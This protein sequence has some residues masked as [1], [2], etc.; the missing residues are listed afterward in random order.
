MHKLLT[1]LLVLTTSLLF[2]QDEDFRNYDNIYQGNIATVRFHLNGLDLSYPIIDINSSGQLR[3][4]FDDLD[5]DVKNY[6]YTIQHCDADW[7]PSDLDEMEYL[8]GFTE[9]RI[10]N[11]QYSFTTRVPYTHYE[12]L[13][14]NNDIGW[15]VSGNYILKVYEDEGDKKLVITR[16]FMVVEPIVQINQRV[17]IPNMVSKSKT[18]QEIDFVVSHE[19]LDIR[20]PRTE[21]KAAVLQNG[22][23]DNA[24][25]DIAPLFV[26]QDELIFDYQNKVIFPAGKEFRYFDMRSLRSR[27]DNVAII[28]PYDDGYEVAITI[29]E[30]R[31]RQPYLF[32]DD[33]NGKYVIEH[34]NQ[35]EADLRG[36]Y[37]DVLLTLKSSMP[38]TEGDVYFFGAI[39]DWQVRPEYKMVYNP[40]V[41]AYVLKALLKQGYYDYQYVIAT[42]KGELLTEELEGNWFETE[43]DYTILVY[44]RPFGTRYDRLIGGY[45][46]DSRDNR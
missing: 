8:T 31:E 38:I 11:Y 21:I 18:H 1:F 46:F 44:Y 32:R 13:L 2:A 6:T 41:S 24:I 27:L 35:P 36:D 29:D 5:A 22:R 37:A 39:S 25:T 28:D 17:A 10:D 40:A 3:L 42:P 34:L 14:P 45:T 20:N 33:I 16:R 4:S 43:N 15:M 12:L 19:K 7:T 26:R 23:W 9:D 30:K